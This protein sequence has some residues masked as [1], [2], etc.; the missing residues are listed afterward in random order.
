M[1][2]MKVKIFLHFKK[3]PLN[4]VKT[5]H[6]LYFGSF[7]IAE[8]LKELYS[9]HLRKLHPDS[10]IVNILLHM[11]YIY[12]P[13]VIYLLNNLNESCMHHDT[14]PKYH[15][16]PLLRI[17]TFPSYHNTIITLEKISLNQMFHIK[18]STYLNFLYC[19]K[20]FTCSYFGRI[21][22]PTKIFTLHLV[23]YFTNHFDLILSLTF[24]FSFVF[25]GLDLF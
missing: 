13:S 15:N 5:L 20:N 24:W 7:K 14:F 1:V 18:Y 4:G 11:V 16:M 23:I 21:R 6:F 8:Q 25:P 2:V 22:D 3:M 17:R 10:A 9:K 12:Y 19:L